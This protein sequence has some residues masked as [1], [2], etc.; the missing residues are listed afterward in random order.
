VGD[1]DVFARNAQLDQ[2]A[3]AGQR[4]GAG[5]RGHQLDVAHVLAH[6]LQAV[7]HRR[8][9]HDGGAVLVV[10]EHGNLQSLAQLALDVE[11]VRRL[12]VFEVD[13]AKGR[14]QGRNDVDQLVRVALIDLDVEDIDA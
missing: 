12:D 11:A 14:L 2:Q 5:A 3:Q 10:V 13:A 4:G 1:P 8:T 6:H 9:H 7:E